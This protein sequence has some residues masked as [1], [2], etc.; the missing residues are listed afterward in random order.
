MTQLDLDKLAKHY[1]EGRISKEEFLYLHSL[2]ARRAKANLSSDPNHSAKQPHARARV[3]AAKKTAAPQQSVH[4]QQNHPEFDKPTLGYY[5]KNHIKQLMAFAG[6]AGVL[7]TLY[8]DYNNKH[9]AEQPGAQLYSVQRPAESDI[10]TRNRTQD[11]QLLADMLLRDQTWNLDLINDFIIQ[12]KKLSSFEKTTVK[13]ADWFGDFT[14][15]LSRQIK[16]QGNMSDDDVYAIYQERALLGLAAQLGLKNH[17]YNDTIKLSDGNTLATN[18]DNSKTPTKQKHDKTI[19][20]EITP[21]SPTVVEPPKNRQTQQ[22]KPSV[23]DTHND[24]GNTPAKIDSVA[25]RK[26]VNRYTIAYNSGDTTDILKMF[27]ENNADKPSTS[28]KTLQSE[29]DT[30]FKSTTQRDVIVSSL[31]WELNGQEAL[32]KGRYLATMLLTNN[33]NQEK[34]QI[35]DLDIRVKLIDDNLIITRFKLGNEKSVLRETQEPASAVADSENQ[36]SPPTHPS[37]AELQDIVVRYVNNYE[38]GNVNGM[39]SLFSGGNWSKGKG[40]SKELKDEYMELFKT[41][42]ARQMFITDM[43]WTFKGNK[44]LGTGD[45]VVQMRNSETGYS[46]Q[47]GKIR[48]VVEKSQEQT[49]INRLFHVLN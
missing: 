34:I 31:A 16:L 2:I 25:L 44:A 30:L 15:S 35:A 46:K 7:L 8:L 39:V 18:I 38:E 6:T 47:T 41:T 13:K 14:N 20:R 43:N 45:L 33:N 1:A 42:S 37:S 19:P 11:I 22:P 26:L 4:Q 32:G 27:G 5:I 12:W 10:S 40:G 9:L 3:S 36:Q 29:Y 49:K 48:I 23:A 17:E 21:T 24:V 28:G